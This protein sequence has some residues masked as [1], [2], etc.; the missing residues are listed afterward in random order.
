MVWR[1]STVGACGSLGRSANAQVG[2][3]LAYTSAKGMA[4]IDRALCLPRAWTSDRSRC[5]AAGVPA[6]TAFATKVALATQ[7]LARAFTA[8]VPARGVPARGVVADC[9]YGRV[10]PLR[11]WLEAQGR[12][13]V[14]GVMPGQVVTH[15]GRPQRATALVGSVPSEAWVRRSAGTGSQGERVHEWAC[16]PLTE[17]APAGMGRWLLVRRTLRDP[18][19]LAYVRAYGP[20]ETAPEELVRI[21]GRRW[22]VEEGFAQAKGEVGLDQYEVRRWTAGHRHITLCLL[23]QAY[24]ASVCAQAQTISA[25]AASKG[26]RSGP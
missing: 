26:G 17:A 14:L 21:A 20:A 8:G 18:T 13:H 23:A 11:R 1:L 16:V 22:S 5:A 3:F 12:P 25:G 6:G 9:L 2:V 15:D 4:F 7:M 19:D 24:L 10:H